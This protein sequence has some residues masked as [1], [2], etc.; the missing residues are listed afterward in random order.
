MRSLFLYVIVGTLIFAGGCTIKKEEVEPKEWP[1]TPAFQDEDTRK[2]L[3]ST[4][5]V[6]DGYYLYTSKTG[7]YS[8]LWPVD[9]TK[10]TFQNKGDAY[11]KLI[12][13]GSSE[14]ENYF[15]EIRT[16]YN[17]ISPKSYLENHLS[18][19]SST[20]QHDGEYKEIIDGDK[21]IYFA[22]EKYT[23]KYSDNRT[24]YYYFSYIR[25]NKKEKGVEF[26][27]SIRCYEDEKFKECEIDERKET[28][29]ALMLM[30][31]VNF[32]KV[33]IDDEQT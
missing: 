25:D 27:Y 5:E 23:P 28:E 16:S 2:M 32:S 7:G 3:D 31:S 26:I 14:K 8:M 15:Y 33:D 29:R 30:K 6:Q 19:L 20:L 12:F 21:I 24:I 17:N 18:N 10:K 13:G 4:E 1:K 11:E 22:R 9:A